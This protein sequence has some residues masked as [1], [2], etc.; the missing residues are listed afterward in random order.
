V[1][2]RIV[3]YLRRYF[4]EFGTAEDCRLF[5][6]ANGG[7][8]RCSSFTVDSASGTRGGGDGCPTLISKR[9]PAAPGPSEAAEG[10]GTT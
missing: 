4:E 7:D 3:E 8:I 9:C 1:W 2:G 6:R 5:V 10:L